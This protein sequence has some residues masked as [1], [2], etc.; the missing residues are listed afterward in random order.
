MPPPRKKY[1]Q[2]S[3]GKLGH[4]DDKFNRYCKYQTKIDNLTNSPIHGIRGVMP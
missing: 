1:H 3:F 4:N 2:T